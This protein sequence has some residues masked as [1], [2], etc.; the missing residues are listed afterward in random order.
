MTTKNAQDSLD[1]L[2]ALLDFAASDVE[3]AIDECTEGGD[4]KAYF[5]ALQRLD[6]ATRAAVQATVVLANIA[7]MQAELAKK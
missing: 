1:K 6:V 5:A 4:Q 2:A 3:N 7:N